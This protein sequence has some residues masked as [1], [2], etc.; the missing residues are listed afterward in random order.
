M[1]HCTKSEVKKK[2]DSRIV[3]VVKKVRRR[4]CCP[5]YSETPAGRCAPICI[6]SCNNGKCVAP[7]QCQCNP[8]PTETAPGYVGS[9]CDRF[10]CLRIDRWGS[11]CDRECSCNENSYCSAS[12]GKC[13]CR[14]GWTGE[15]CTEECTPSMNCDNYELPPIL[16]PEANIIHETFI[17][18]R[19]QQLNAAEALERSSERPHD[20]QSARD[21]QKQQLYSIHTM[22]YLIVISLLV[23]TVIYF[24]YKFEKLKALIHNQAYSYGYASSSSVYSADTTNSGSQN[25]DDPKYAVTAKGPKRFFERY[26]IHP[27]TESHLVKSHK[28]PKPNLYSELGSVVYATPCEKPSNNSPGRVVSATSLRSPPQEEQDHEYQVPRSVASPR[29]STQDILSRPLPRPGDSLRYEDPIYEEISPR[30][31]SHK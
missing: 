5:G 25:G 17:K 30:S 6:N 12:T 26:L 10:A 21:D 19:S 29:P 9:N 13:I 31:Q 7:N 16:E 24:W 2:I 4:V 23:Y 20:D 8:E 22:I 27:Q 15:N 1:F 18:D 14:S 3:T 28:S 11:K